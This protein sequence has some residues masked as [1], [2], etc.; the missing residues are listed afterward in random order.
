MEL[1]NTIRLTV[2][3]AAAGAL[4]VGVTMFHSGGDI[5]TAG[6]L[7]RPSLVALAL[8]I[9]SL[10]LEVGRGIDTL[11]T[12]ATGQAARLQGYEDQIERDVEHVRRLWV[13]LQVVAWLLIVPTAALVWYF[14]NSVTIFL[15]G[16]PDTRFMVSCGRQGIGILVCFFALCAAIQPVRFG[17][18]LLVARAYPLGAARVASRQET[19]IEGEE[20]WIY[21]PMSRIAYFKLF[22]VLLTAC[23]LVSVMVAVSYLRVADGGIG[24]VDVLGTTEVSHPWADVCSMTE[25][26]SFSDNGPE[27]NY[28]IQFSDGMEWKSGWFDDNCSQILQWDPKVAIEFAADRANLPIR[29]CHD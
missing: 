11:S 8:L 27:H 10:S 1:R 28:K 26:H 15:F 7:V 19:A 20:G 25:T 16:T 18:L 21:I 2:V 29:T 14:H 4:A 3:V 12:A 22:F 17:L 23:L 6:G 13:F 24:F 5:Q 9:G